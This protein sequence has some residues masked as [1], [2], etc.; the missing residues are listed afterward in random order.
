MQ[1]LQAITPTAYAAVLDQ[2]APIGDVGFA[3]SAAWTDWDQL[4][5]EI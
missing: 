5:D 4:V 3:L 2:D 1:K